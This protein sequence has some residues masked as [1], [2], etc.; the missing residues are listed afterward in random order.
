[1][2]KQKPIFTIVDG[3]KILLGTVEIDEIHGD[4]VFHPFKI[5]EVDIHKI[6][7]TRELGFVRLD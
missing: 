5:T 6:N 4:P 1:M 3:K 2:T 7:I